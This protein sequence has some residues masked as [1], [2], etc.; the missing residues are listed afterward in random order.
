MGEWPKEQKTEVRRKKC[1]VAV[2]EIR[3][4]SQGKF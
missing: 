2:F 1:F 4:G 3:V